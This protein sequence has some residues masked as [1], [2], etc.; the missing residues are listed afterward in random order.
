MR[1]SKIKPKKHYSYLELAII[2]FEIAD[3][4]YD[5]YGEAYKLRNKATRRGVLR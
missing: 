2:S 1:F 3:L 5:R 4:F